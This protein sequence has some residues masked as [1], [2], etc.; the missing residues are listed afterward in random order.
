MLLLLLINEQSEIDPSSY[1]RPQQTGRVDQSAQVLQ[2][3]MKQKDK[4]MFCV[5]S[6]THQIEMRQ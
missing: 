1:N 6:M 2:T 3:Q 5:I 4:E